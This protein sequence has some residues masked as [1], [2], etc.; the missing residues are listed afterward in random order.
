[1]DPV[2]WVYIGLMA[3]SVIVSIALRPHPKAP[4][5]STGDLQV[6]TAED[7]RE[8]MDIAGTSWIDDPN[9]TWYGD[10]STTPIKRG[11]GKK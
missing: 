8:V 3:F 10:L 6:P 1:M 2:T 9:V 4:P 11:G 5:T 7:G